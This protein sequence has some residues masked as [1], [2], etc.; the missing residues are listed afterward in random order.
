MEEFLHRVSLLVGNLKANKN[1][2][3][4]PQCLLE[5]NSIDERERRWVG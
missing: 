3:C 1:G 2:N 5:N 4:R